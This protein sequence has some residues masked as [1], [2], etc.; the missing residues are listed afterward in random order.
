LTMDKQ[1]KDTTCSNGSFKS[2]PQPG[3]QKQCFCDKFGYYNTTQVD[4][5]KSVWEAKEKKEEDEKTAR[6]QAEKVKEAQEEAERLR[7]KAINA[8]KEAEAEKKRR[9]ESGKGQW[10]RN[11]E[12]ALAKEKQKRENW[13]QRTLSNLNT[14][15]RKELSAENARFKAR[16]AQRMYRRALK[17]KKRANAIDKVKLAI[18]AHNRKI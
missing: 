12:E 11:Q 6:S 14:A 17:A 1:E 5:D 9:L 10:F 4:S 16:K 3:V 2:D 8:A 7:I 13:Y 18:E 15:Q